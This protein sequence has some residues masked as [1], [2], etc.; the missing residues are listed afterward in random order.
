MLVSHPN[1]PEKLVTVTLT[2][3]SFPL[4]RPPSLPPTPCINPDLQGS[5]ISAIQKVLTAAE[6]VQKEA[7][8]STP[9]SG[10]PPRSPLKPYVPTDE[11]DSMDGNNDTRDSPVASLSL[12][13]HSLLPLNSLPIVSR[14]VA[15]QG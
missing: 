1:T 12:S 2:C 10:E 7:I 4:F 3:F 13:P 14:Q 11:D 8:P 5:I 15:R 6:D 9:S